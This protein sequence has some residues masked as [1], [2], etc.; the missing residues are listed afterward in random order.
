VLGPVLISPVQERHGY[1]AESPVKV[2][3]EDEG[4]GA[5]LIR[6]KAERT[7]TV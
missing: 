4:T 2:Q 7:G 1:T 5:S 6:G 3:E